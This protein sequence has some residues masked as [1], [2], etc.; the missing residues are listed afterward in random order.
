MAR[1]HAGQG[2][3]EVFFEAQRTRR[4]AIEIWR[5]ELAPAVRAEHVP[6]QAV[7]EHDD[8][9]FGFCGAGRVSC[10]HDGFLRWH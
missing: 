5:G 2:T 9:V 7:E 4:E 3:D 10:G 6:V 8:D 1:G